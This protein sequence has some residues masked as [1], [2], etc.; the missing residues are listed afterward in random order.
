[1][2]RTLRNLSPLIPYIAVAIGM[3]ALRSAWLAIGLYHA[4][5]LA[6][7]LSNRSKSRSPIF[8]KG[9][10]ALYLTIAIF[11]AGGFIFYLLWPYIASG[12]VISDKLHDYGINKTIWLYFAV[13]FCVVNSITEEFFWRGYLGD[14]RKGPVLNDFLF[15]GYHALV[16]LAFASPVWTLPVIAA[17]AFAGW[18]WRTLR[19][20]RGGLAVPILTHLAADVSIV[21]AVHFR[22]FV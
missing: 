19:R 11:A 21:A 17:C 16:L 5:A 9:P 14:D 15:A 12:S 7:V 20:I 3:Y 13:Y 18:L 4:G 6:V 8:S 22:L 1:M 10:A 2:K